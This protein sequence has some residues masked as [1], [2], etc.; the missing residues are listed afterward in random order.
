MPKMAVVAFAISDNIRDFFGELQQKALP[1]K[2]A[3][4]TTLKATTH[5]AEKPSFMYI[6]GQIKFVKTICEQFIG[7]FFVVNILL[8]KFRVIIAAFLL[9]YLQWNKNV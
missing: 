1:K 3:S 9:L 7:N 5:N 6:A 2:Y 4:I 8:R